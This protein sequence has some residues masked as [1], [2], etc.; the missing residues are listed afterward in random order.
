MGGIE[1]QQNNEILLVLDVGVEIGVRFPENKSSKSSSK[2][3]TNV[4]SNNSL[5]TGKQ[6]LPTSNPII[7][8]VTSSLTETVKTQS[9]SENAK[10]FMPNMDRFV[11]ATP[12]FANL[13]PNL[14]SM[15]FKKQS[16]LLVCFIRFRVDIGKELFD[17]ATASLKKTS[18]GTHQQIASE[19]IEKEENYIQRLMNPPTNL[20][21]FV[22]AISKEVK[23]FGQKVILNQQKRDNH[24]YKI[25]Y[26][27]VCI[28]GKGYVIIGIHTPI[29]SM[30]DPILY[31]I[32][33]GEDSLNDYIKIL[34]PNTPEDERMV[35]IIEF[36]VS[37]IY[38]FPFSGLLA[39]ALAQFIIIRIGN[40]ITSSSIFQE[41]KQKLTNIV[42]VSSKSTPNQQSTPLP[43]VTA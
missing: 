38:Q 18:E 32:G 14:G 42:M 12:N 34:S 33:F 5:L 23:N 25:N 36:L 31:E 39:K 21:K 15:K 26:Y 37:N 28:P 27:S 35:Y 24:K 2:T 9:T 19:T 11:I 20:K 10:K 13:S 43:V 8:N 4:I 7:S 16:E 1:I 3:S 17:Q 6:E 41:T 22:K 40:E 30:K 29:D